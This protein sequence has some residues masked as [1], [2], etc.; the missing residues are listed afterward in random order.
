MTKVAF[1]AQGAL[2]SD[3]LFG[4]SSARDNVLERFV[5]LKELLEQEGIPCHTVDMVHAEE[6]GVL[7]FHNLHFELSSVLKVI[8]ANPAV[9][10]IYIPNEPA[11]IAPLHDEKILKGLPVDAVMTWND[12]IAGKY[13]N[14]HKCNI[15]QP[16]IFPE[17]IPAVPFPE[18]KFICS[19]FS[20]KSSFS[21]ESLYIERIRSIEYFGSRP[22]GMDLYGTGWSSSHLSAV[23]KSY[24]GPCERKSE[25]LQ[26]YKFAIAYEN[27][28]D[29]PGLITEKIFDCFAAGTVPI[30]HGAPNIK[31]Y[32]PADCFIDFRDFVDYEKLAIFLENM[33]ESQYQG[34]L[35]AVKKFVSSPDYFEFTSKSYAQTLTLRIKQLI[36][37][38]RSLR[39]V[40]SFK[41]QLL[42]RILVNPK[43]LLKCLRLRKMALDIVTVW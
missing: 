6:I 33:T 15:G 10:L 41:K 23:R 40:L 1:V 19:I 3:R 37:S 16:V 17:S 39:S 42:E 20:N 21:S 11:F 9:V 27:V 13:S 29:C 8:R 32:I 12:L 14:V 38:E 26:R 43:M 28:A 5:L 7:I 22:Y 18:K 36:M 25:V 2:A 24:R 4:I 30:Y 34:Y 31:E 35:D